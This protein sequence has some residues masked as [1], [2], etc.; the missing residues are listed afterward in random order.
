[1]RKFCQ[2]MAC[3]LAVIGFIAG[4][5]VV[6]SQ[7]EICLPCDST[8][9][10]YY[11]SYPSLNIFNVPELQSNMPSDVII[12]Y[13]I[14]DSVLRNVTPIDFWEFIQ[15]LGD[16][17]TLNYILKYMYLM[18]DHDPVRY[19]KYL[20]TQ[21]Y[22]RKGALGYENH[23]LQR[24]S[25]LSTMRKKLRVITP[26]YILHVRVNE[27]VTTEIPEG[28]RCK[29]L[30]AAHSTVVET[31]KGQVLPTMGMHYR[32][33]SPAGIVAP[34]T[35][36]PSNFVFEYCPYWPR[37]WDGGTKYG[38]GTDSDPWVKPNYEY[39]V[40]TKFA[41][42]CGDENITYSA[43]FPVGGTLSFGMYPIIEGNVI[44]E[45]NAWGWGEVVPVDVFKENLRQFINA[46]KYYGD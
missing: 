11:Y 32:L 21:P 7:E 20:S 4:S 25:Q 1:M 2:I 30:I 10:G 15:T 6:K 5:Q 9:K 40:F 29:K 41:G 31:I 22:P 42:H 13:I 19:S 17:D 36:S 18:A 3:L 28:L 33:N 39:I 26:E 8:A 12:G 38:I 35:P 34:I 44:D 43:M 37:E 23:L 27:T 45:G 24:T 16:G 14:A 46:I